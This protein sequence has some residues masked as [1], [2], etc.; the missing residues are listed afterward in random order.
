MTLGGED[1]LW[2][3]TLDEAKARLLGSDHRGPEA[4][5]TA[6]WVSNGMLDPVRAEI[7][8]AQIRGGIEHLVF[9]LKRKDDQIRVEMDL[10]P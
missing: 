8:R 9:Y 7:I 3:L 5:W 4:S 1:T 2:L 6:Y 10:R